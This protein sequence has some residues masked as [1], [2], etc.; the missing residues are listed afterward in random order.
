M[1][2]AVARLLGGALQKSREGIDEAEKQAG[3]RVQEAVDKSRAAARKGADHAESK[4]DKL[5]ANAKTGAQDAGLAARNVWNR[6]VEKSHDLADKTEKSSKEALSS[7]AGTVDVARGAVRGAISRGIE[8][9]KE[10]VGKAQAAVGIAT[11]S[12]ESKAQSTVFGVSEVEKALH[13]RYDKPDGLD[14]GI[15]EALAERYKP[16]DSRDNTVLRGV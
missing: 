1:E 12:A 4:A 13:E 11:E 9:G 3:P 5:A 15:D 16:I 7:G 10:A 6:G 2:T 14:K 8:K